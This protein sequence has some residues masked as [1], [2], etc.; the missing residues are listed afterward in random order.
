MRYLSVIL[1]VLVFLGFATIS[2][3]QEK[4]TEAQKAKVQ[5]TEMQKTGMQ[6]AAAKVMLPEAVSKVVGETCPNAEI[7][8]MDME[9][10]AGITLYDIEFKAGRGEIEVAEDGTVMD[11]TTMVE[12]KDVPGA[13][14]AVI[15]KAAE[16]AT[17]K[18]IEKSEIR[19]EIQKEGEI[20]HIVKNAAPKLVYEVALVKGKEM[21]EMQVAPDGKIVEALKWRSSSEEKD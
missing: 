20:G 13:A 8:K 17:I 3:A 6:K 12:M 4:T 5:K 1:T 16:G 9:K 21:G 10:E 15:Q 14:A 7:D 19:A 2:T 18:E 11:V